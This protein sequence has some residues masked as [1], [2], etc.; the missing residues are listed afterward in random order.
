MGGKPGFS[1]QGKNHRLREFESRPRGENIWI[2]D[3]GNSDSLPNTK[4]RY[5]YPFN[6]PWRPIGV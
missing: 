3:K 4:K 5:S 1:Q 6:R 2:E